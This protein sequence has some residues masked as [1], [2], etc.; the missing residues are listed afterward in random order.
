MS[1]KIGTAD[2]RHGLFL[3]PM[4]GVSDRTFRLL[5]REWGAEYLVSEMVSAKALCYEQKGKRKESATLGTAPLAAITEG[6]APM[7][8]QIF[9]S[10]P[11]F[12]A[13]AAR[14]L[15]SG[16]YRGCTSAVPPVAIDINMGC[17][18]RK[19]TG[20]GEGSA[21][22]K[23]PKLIGQIVSEVVRA[24]SLP[25]TVKIRA[26]WDASSVNAPEVAK[27]AEQAGAS[28]VCVHARTREQLYTP[29]IDLG[30]IEAVKRAVGI[31]VIGNGDVN[32][33][34]SAIRMMKETGCDGV[35]IG[36]GA[37][38]NPWIFRQIAV[39]LEGKSYEAP[40][41]PE[42]METAKSHLDGMIAHKGARVGLAEAK[43]HMAWYVAGVHGA[44]AA[45]SAIMNAQSAEEIRWILSD[46]AQ[47]GDA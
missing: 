44:A 10:E 28:L 29:G 12:M 13:E 33:A 27:I 3:A 21:L 19:V 30:V 5:C 42:R 4:A 46:L 26:G 32:S 47:K 36:R 2:L 25:V 43:K 1:I 6:E 40:S 35:M 14:L 37:M 38:G 9:G 34:E 11:S 16:E 7:A 22:M 15:Q 24:T 41:L 17:P 18:V 39:A 23:N 45:R 31:P 20:N 8:V